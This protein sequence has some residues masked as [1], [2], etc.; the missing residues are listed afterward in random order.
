MA[1]EIDSFFNGFTKLIL[2]IFLLSLFQIVCV[3][4]ILFYSFLS[5]FIDCLV[6]GLKEVCNHP[7]LIT[8]LC[9]STPAPTHSDDVISQHNR[10][11]YT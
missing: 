9:L 10:V 6:L 2:F 3:K 1:I 8:F 4:I 5:L 11:G 7:S